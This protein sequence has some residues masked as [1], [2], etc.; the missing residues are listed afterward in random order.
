MLP[1]TQTIVAAVLASG[2]TSVAINWL[3]GE[4][5]RA[6][7]RREKRNELLGVAV[8]DLLSTRKKLLLASAIADEMHTFLEI[9]REVAV[10]FLPNLLTTYFRIDDS[11]HRR[12]ERAGELLAATDPALAAELS[13]RTNLLK[14]MSV[15]ADV[16]P[17]LPA[18]DRTSY[19]VTELAQLK[20]T[21]LPML[22]AA[23][24]ELS[25]R[26]GRRIARS[27]RAN[28]RK[29]LQL[30]ENDRANMRSMCEIGKKWHY[31]ESAKA[32]SNALSD[33]SG[34]R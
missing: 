29:P 7:E 9:P 11:V 26:Q 18:M 8:L 4:V 15:L 5:S 14:G 6:R 20:N 25:K 33:Q 17:N 34:T 12:Y 3:F 30:T 2:V 32:A 1:T 21:T 16:L 28:L 19:V 13:G 31:A 24:M 27:V 10:P 23:I 22:D